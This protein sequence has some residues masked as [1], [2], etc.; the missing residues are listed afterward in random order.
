MDLLIRLIEFI[1]R[2]ALEQNKRNAAPPISAMP[3]ASLPSA[4]TS[5]RPGGMSAVSPRAAVPAAMPAQRPSQPLVSRAPSPDPL[6][7]DRGWRSALTVL[8]VIALIVMVGVWAVY[9][10]GVK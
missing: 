9:M 3:S 10:A 4:Q 2:S 7:D 8:A 1:I 5:Q 6:Y